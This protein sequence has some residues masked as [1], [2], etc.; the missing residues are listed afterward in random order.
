MVM[1]VELPAEPLR[2]LRI[3]SVQFTHQSMA[4]PG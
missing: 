2:G 3:L 1:G 4:R